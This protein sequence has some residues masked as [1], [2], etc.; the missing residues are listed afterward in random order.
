M[1]RIEVHK[2]ICNEGHELFKAKDADYGGAYSETRKEFPNVILLFLTIKL[3]RLK[4]L[5]NGNSPNV[6]E[7]IDDTLKDMS[8]YCNMEL[9]ERRLEQMEEELLSEATRVQ[10]VMDD[11]MAVGTD[12]MKTTEAISN[13]AAK[14]HAEHYWQC[15]G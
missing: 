3:N 12:M 10:A 5:M 4:H 13:L 9:T 2:E 7:S 15:R 8:N 14:E 1:N 6:A 11:L